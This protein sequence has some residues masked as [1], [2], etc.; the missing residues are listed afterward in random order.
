MASMRSESAT[1][2][3]T[4]IGSASIALSCGGDSS[5]IAIEASDSDGGLFVILFSS[6]RE[7]RNHSAF[8]ARGESG[9]EKVDRLGGGDRFDVSGRKAEQ[10][11][12]LYELGLEFRVTEFTGYDLA[13]RDLTGR[14]DRQT[15][16]QFAFECRIDPQGAIV[17]C[18]NRTLVLV[19]HEL[20][21]F[22][23]A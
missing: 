5:L 1:G 4:A 20:Y 16:H 19:E 8:S 6:R 3:V 13:E 2:L 9:R 17:E 11:D 15:Q 10:L 14:R 12:A 22:A 23:A 7:G 21:F 18:E